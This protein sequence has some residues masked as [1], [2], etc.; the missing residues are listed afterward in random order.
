[1]GTEAMS[2]NRAVSHAAMV[3]RRSNRSANTPATG[4]ST[5]DGR[6]RSTIVAENAAPLAAG[7]SNRDCA[8]P[9]VA[10]IASQSPNEARPSTVHSRRKGLIR[11]TVWMS[12]RVFAMLLL[13]S[14]KTAPG[15][16]RD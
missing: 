5:S 15:R 16:L 7:S 6:S 8:N 11:S 13:E 1:M 14:Q 10:K 2:R 12:A 3:L 9:A 4:P